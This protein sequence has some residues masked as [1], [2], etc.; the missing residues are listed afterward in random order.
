MIEH[1]ERLCPEL[2]L[3][4]L[5]DGDVFEDREVGIG[6]TRA[7]QRISGCISK[8]IVVYECI[9]SLCLRSDWEHI[10]SCIDAGFCIAAD[11]GFC[12]AVLAR[13]MHEVWTHRALAHVCG[14]V[15]Q[16]DV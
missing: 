4:P 2:E 14:V 16:A 3:H 15:V 13:R 8:G 12:A 1:I 11:V 10:R 7:V 6:E 9:S 5:P